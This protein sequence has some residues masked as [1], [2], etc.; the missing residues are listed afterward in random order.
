M[1]NMDMNRSEPGESDASL[2]AK[3]ASPVCTGCFKLKPTASNRASPLCARCRNHNLSIRLTGHKRYCKYRHCTCRK[4]Q[5]TATRQRKMAKKTRQQRARKQDKDKELKPEEVSPF[6]FH[7]AKV[8]ILHGDPVIVD[9]SASDVEDALESESE[10]VEKK[11]KNDN[12]EILLEYIKR[13]MYHFRFVWPLVSLVTTI[14]KYSQE[15]ASEADIAEAFSR[16]SREI[17]EIRMMMQYGACCYPPILPNTMIA[18]TYEEQMPYIGIGTSP[19]PFHLWPLTWPLN[20]LTASAAISTPPYPD[21]PPESSTT[22]HHTLLMI[23]EASRRGQLVESK[24][25]RAASEAIETAVE[26][27]VVD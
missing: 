8:H 20:S 26:T 19:N 1:D 14:V 24:E 7:K 3:R 4:C 11:R 17:H 27:N 9:P 25:S 22:Y 12:L 2:E 18:P 23:G 21:S 6:L 16:I 5:E 10:P 13:E 15:Y